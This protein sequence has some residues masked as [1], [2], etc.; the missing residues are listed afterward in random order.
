MPVVDDEV[1]HRIS[2]AEACD[3]LML[4]HLDLHAYPMARLARE[5]VVLSK[6]I[7]LDLSYNWIES[8]PAAISQCGSLI[9]L[10]LQ[11]NPLTALPAGISELRNLECLDISSTKVSELPNEVATMSNL[12]EIDWNDTP[13]ELTMVKEHEIPVNDLPALMGLL[14][15]L[16]TREKLEEQLLETLNG[17]KYMKEADMPGSSDIINDLVKT[18]SDMYQDL[19]ELAL[20]VRRAES[21]LPE[22]LVE[23]TPKNLLK[24][25]SNF[26]EMQRETTRVRLSADVEIKLRA[27]YFDRAERSEIDAMLAS[28]YKSVKSL[29]DIEHLVRYAKEIMPDDPK[30]VTGVVV[31]TNLLAHQQSLIEKREEVI[32]LLCTSM[33]GLYPEQKPEDIQSGGREVAAAFATER[34][35]TK[36]ECERLTQ[37]AAEAG[38][39]FPPN[40]PG[41]NPVEIRNAAKVMFSAK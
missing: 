40:F 38:K 25:K 3:M 8:L 17:T 14:H 7:R 21:L 35:A 22:K 20:F 13:L 39:L 32:K 33:T 29:E 1:E 30:I 4:S 34:F 24:V 27:I 11:Y 16:Y 5:E 23:C 26:E 28:I 36:K 10:W 2:R 9:E 41:I 19:E 15:D 6:I 18:L 31:W 12:D 37:V